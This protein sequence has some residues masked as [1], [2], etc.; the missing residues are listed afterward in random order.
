MKTRL[1]L[2]L[3]AFALSFGIAQM[4]PA[5]AAPP[6]K[7]EQFCWTVRCL[8]SAPICGNYINENGQLACGCH[9]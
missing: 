3:A 7:C 4:A 9:A 8:P 5:A 6:S 1:T 2:A